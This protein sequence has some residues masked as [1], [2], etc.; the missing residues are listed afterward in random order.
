MDRK[1]HPAPE[2]VEKHLVI[3]HGDQPCLF[4][5]LGGKACPE[6]LPVEIIAAVWGVTQPEALQHGFGEAPFLKIT[7][8]DTLPLFRVIQHILKILFRKFRYNE[9]AFSF[10]L[11]GQLRI[12]ELLLFYLNIVFP[13]QPLQGIRVGEALQVHDK[14]NRIAPFAASETFIDPF[15]R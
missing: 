9:Q 8:A 4:Q 12:G 14:T 11:G 13:G 2:P 1:N 10:I 6:G 7:G 15:G 5:H 3:F